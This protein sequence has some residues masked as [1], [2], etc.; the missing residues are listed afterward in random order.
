MIRDPHPEVLTNALYNPHFSEEMAVSVAKRRN[1]PSE[2]LG[3]LADDRRFRDNYQLKVALSRNPKTPVR[4]ILSLLKYIHILDLSDI[5]R[6][7][8]V[9]VNVRQRV[10]VMITDRLK[11]MPSGIMKSLSRRASSSIIL[12]IMEK[13][14]EG[15]IRICLDSPSLTEGNL[16][17][18]INRQAT[19]GPVVRQ[20][21]SHQKWS[22]R[23]YV[24]FALIRNFH[25]PMTEVVK[26]IRT[27]KATDL[28]DLYADPKLP[29]A[30]RP[31]IFR[32][33]QERGESPEHPPDR[34]YR[35]SDDDD[36][37]IRSDGDDV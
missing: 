20:I 7:R 12:A 31:F 26:F 4:A 17:R 32:E 24:R 11:G 19:P 2:V 6:D 10:E 18:I 5:T 21:A 3:M 23:Y 30:T 14:D 33:F 9:P 22:L 8:N 25:T 27:M 36:T 37:L 28:R 34:T 35:L 29:A 16:C 1:V 15:V 13:G